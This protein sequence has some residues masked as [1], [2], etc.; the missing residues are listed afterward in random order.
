MPL[1]IALLLIPRA[2]LVVIALSGGWVETAF[3]DE[4][5]LPA[6][7]FF[8]LPWTTLSWV[9]AE[10]PAAGLNPAEVVLIAFGFLFD[11]Y[12]YGRFQA[13]RDQSL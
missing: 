3:S 10:G 4:W 8:V 5:I 7:G 1:A 9:L 12:T 6:F 11:L 2:L 13:A